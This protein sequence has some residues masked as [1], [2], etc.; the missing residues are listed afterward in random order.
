MR[1][2]IGL[3][4]LLLLAACG[5]PD[6]QRLIAE[7][8]AHFGPGTNQDYG[9]P[10]LES[11]LIGAWLLCSDPGCS[12]DQGGFQMTADHR[13]Y[14]FSANFNI[15]PPVAAGGG[16]PRGAG[17]LAGQSS[18]SCQL[19]GTYSFSGGVLTFMDGSRR[20]TQV[21]VLRQGST[22]VFSIVGNGQRYGKKVDL[23]LSCSSS[24]A[25]PF[26]DSNPTTVGT[27]GGPKAGP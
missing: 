22:T 4:S 15:E 6:G 1:G 12:Q 27:A 10:L 3:G 21:T 17:T 23:K 18:R 9:A 8:T 24:N 2:S 26:N 7:N 5:G 16:I 20:T 25:I 13:I 11:D 19:L 14:S